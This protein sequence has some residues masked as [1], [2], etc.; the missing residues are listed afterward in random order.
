MG[1]PLRHQMVLN[2]CA[3]LPAPGAK[4]RRVP[5]FFGVQVFVQGP[6]GE[7]E[8]GAGVLAGPPKR[9]GGG[10]GA[11]RCRWR[12]VGDPAFCGGNCP[13]SP[14]RLSRASADAG[15]A[16]SVEDSSSRM[17]L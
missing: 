3:C 14:T 15:L 10:S 13:A 4:R 16:G 1:M 6:R 12:G 5:E 7:A 9:S 2:G 8:E 17:F 11:P